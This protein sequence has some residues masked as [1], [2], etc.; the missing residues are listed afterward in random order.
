MSTTGSTT[1]DTSDTS[2]LYTNPIT[3]SLNDDDGCKDYDASIE[4]LVTQVKKED[5]Y[6]QPSNVS[7]HC[8]IFINLCIYFHTHY[9]IYTYTSISL[10]I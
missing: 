1:N 4:S 7:P 9:Y 5:N 3:S 8:Y 6:R 10:D 2:P